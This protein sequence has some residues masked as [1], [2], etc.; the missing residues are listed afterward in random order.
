RKNILSLHLVFAFGTRLT[1]SSKTTTC[2]GLTHDKHAQFSFQLITELGFIASM[3][4]SNISYIIHVEFSGIDFI[5]VLGNYLLLLFSIAAKLNRS[6][7]LKGLFYFFLDYATKY[8][9][10]IFIYTIHYYYMHV[11]CYR[12]RYSI[13]NGAME[14]GAFRKVSEISVEFS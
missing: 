3:L 4:A 9:R 13:L 7:H 8:N 12:Y 1:P 6:K 14:E 2:S 11:R 5:K 10:L